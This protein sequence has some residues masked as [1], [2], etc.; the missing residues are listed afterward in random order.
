MG[1]IDKLVAAILAAALA[2]RDDTPSTA[3]DYVSTYQGVLEALKDHE[4]K[5]RS[6]HPQDD[7]WL[8]VNEELK[9]KKNAN[10]DRT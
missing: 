5:K 9:K 2:S 6:V 4:L 7:S 10:A 1:D 8:A 3:D